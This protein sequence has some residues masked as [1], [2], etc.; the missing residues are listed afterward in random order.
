[1]AR[2]PDADRKALL[3]VGLQPP[4]IQDGAEGWHRGSSEERGV[5]DDLQQLEHLV[6]AQEGEEVVD[7]GD[8][9]VV[10][11]QERVLVEMRIDVVVTRAPGTDSRADRRSSRVGGGDGT[12]EAAESS[13]SAP[14]QT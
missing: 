1:P 13:A 8:V 7:G 2:R 5:V 12:R 6:F 3:V 4:A 10:D 9:D 11:D 14:R